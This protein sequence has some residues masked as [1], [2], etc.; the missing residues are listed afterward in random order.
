MAFKGEFK[1][2]KCG[3]KMFITQDDKTGQYEK[4]KTCTKCG[5]EK[6]IGLVRSMFYK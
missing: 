3:H 1:C 4:P 6:S 2:S 5:A